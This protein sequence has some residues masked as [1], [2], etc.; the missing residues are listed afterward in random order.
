MPPH[1][2]WPQLQVCS[3][4]DALT[5]STL[6]GLQMCWATMP[7]CSATTITL[8]ALKMVLF[9]SVLLRCSR[10]TPDRSQ[11]YQSGLCPRTQ[12]GRIFIFACLCVFLMSLGAVG[13]LFVCSHAGFYM[14]HK[15]WV[16]AYPERGVWGGGGGA[17]T[18]PCP[19]FNL[20]GFLMKA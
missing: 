16:S 7:P 1:F 19:N 18:L 20:A 17:W 11:G 4:G 9:L 6:L 8:A 13:V 3:F 10:E 14:F 5:H 12:S 15:P 2:F